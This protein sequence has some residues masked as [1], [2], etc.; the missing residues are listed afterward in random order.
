MNDLPARVHIHEEGPREGFQ[1]EPGPIATAR[2]V[3][4]IDALARTGLDHIQV[5][6]FVNPKRVPGMADADEVVAALTPVEGVQYSALWLNQQGLLRALA[7]PG[8]TLEGKLTLY[9]SPAFLMKNQ[10][11]TPDEQLAAQPELLRMYLH[12]GVPVRS[13]F[14]T[15]A[16]GCNFE[17][18]IPPARV[19]ELITRQREIAREQDVVLDHFGLA[20]TMGWANPQLVRRVVGAVRDAHPDISLSLHLHD[21]RGLGLA[22]A[23]AG[24]EMGVDRFDTAVAGLGGCPFAALKGAAGNICTEDFV[25]LCEE[26]GIDTGVDLDALIEC[27]RLAEDIVGHPL[28]GKVKAGGSLS[29]MRRRIG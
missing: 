27:A 11:R 14:V 28:P 22:N 24:L 3:E 20:D 7:H 16:F 1:I 21:T 26:M 8:L 6:S 17:G 18:D 25:L 19:V 9:A 4:L 10:N 15:A 13:G 29:A 12:Y 5:V 23:L 2:K